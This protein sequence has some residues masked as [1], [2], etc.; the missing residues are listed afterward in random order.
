MAE[1]L[2]N[3][4]LKNQGQNF[5]GRDDKADMQSIKISEKQVDF[6]QK[7]ENVCEKQKARAS[8]KYSVFENF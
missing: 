2:K 1:S 7:V 3:A 4:A 8:V 6:L 5:Y